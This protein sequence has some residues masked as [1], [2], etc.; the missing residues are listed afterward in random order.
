MRW[1]TSASRVVVNMEPL[2][3]S[4]DSTVRYLFHIDTYVYI[5]ERRKTYEVIGREESNQ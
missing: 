4:L 5:D 1:L 2:A 3:A